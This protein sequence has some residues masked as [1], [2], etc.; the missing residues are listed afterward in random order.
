[1]DKKTLETLARNA[2]CLLKTKDG[3][4]Q[5]PNCQLANSEAVDD[6]TL[7]LI[8]VGASVAAC[9]APCLEYHINA[10]RKAGASHAEL[11]AAVQIGEKVRQRPAD[12]IA[13]SCKDLDI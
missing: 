13:Q 1:M 2:C 4:D 9:C 12:I 10:A 11:A 8:A 5:V 3:S 7:E 6:K